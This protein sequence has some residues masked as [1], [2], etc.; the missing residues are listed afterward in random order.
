MTSATRSAGPDAHSSRHRVAGPCDRLPARVGR[1]PAASHRRPCHVLRPPSQCPPTTHHHCSSPLRTFPAPP[2]L[3][4]LGLAE[5][6]VTPLLECR[7]PL[8]RRQPVWRRRPPFRGRRPA[9]W[10]DEGKSPSKEPPRRRE[11]EQNQARH[12]HQ[13]DPGDVGRIALFTR[14]IRA[15]FGRETEASQKH[16]E[17]RPGERQADGGE[18][19]HH[20]STRLARH[21][22]L[23]GPDILCTPP[24]T[25]TPVA[26]AAQRSHR[27]RGQVRRERTSTSSMS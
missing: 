6:P 2:E 24:R 13:N 8:G 26:S 20:E 27:D 19:E 1:D 16:H 17:Q 7:C 4:E 11:E 22:L 10:R 25:V 15:G 21:R 12:G 14:K 18:Q 3:F 23:Y 5:S 9:R